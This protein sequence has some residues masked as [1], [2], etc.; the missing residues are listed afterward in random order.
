MFERKVYEQCFG[1]YRRYIPDTNDGRLLYSNVGIKTLL[2]LWLNC[3]DTE[4]PNE[5]VIPSWTTVNNMAKN[6]F[7]GRTKTE[8]CVHAEQIWGIPS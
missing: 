8:T 5:Y 3:Y 7:K 2:D 4:R 6:Y 1:K